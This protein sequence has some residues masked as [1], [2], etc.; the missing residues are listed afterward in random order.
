MNPLLIGNFLFFDTPSIPPPG[1]RVF[2]FYNPL[3]LIMTE[4]LHVLPMSE[5]S[6]LLTNTTKQFVAALRNDRPIGELE[7]LRDCLT[8]IRVEIRKREYSTAGR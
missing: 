5:L 4:N 6:N 7:H 8:A 3:S 1:D 2:I